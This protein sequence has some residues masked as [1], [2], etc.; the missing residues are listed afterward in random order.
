MA[1]KGNTVDKRE[2]PRFYMELAIKAMKNSEDELNK[3]TPNP[4]VGAVLV[5]PDGAYETAYRGEY[6]EGDHAE[7]TLLDKKFRTK[8]VSDC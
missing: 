5:F 7:Y 6:R 2:E 3:D 1:K 4:R 8:D